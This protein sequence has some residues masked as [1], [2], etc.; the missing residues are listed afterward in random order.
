MT[1]SIGLYWFFFICSV[2]FH[3][4][5]FNIGQK[6][7]LNG[8]FIL[9]VRSCKWLANCA[10]TTNFLFP[11]T[12]LNL[13]KWVINSIF[14][15]SLPPRTL[16]LNTISHYLRS[17]KKA[18]LGSFSWTPFV[19]ARKVKLLDT[20]QHSSLTLSLPCGTFLP[21]ARTQ[22]YPPLVNFWDCKK[23]MRAKSKRE[24]E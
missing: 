18:Y 21:C 16:E 2:C 13:T 6:N 5:I 24:R 8:Q 17:P 3:L 4:D 12:S 14:F 7:R 22:T 11:F 15:L 20:Y 9:I 10:K 19:C 23:G 1:H